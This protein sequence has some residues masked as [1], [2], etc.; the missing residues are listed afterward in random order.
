MVDTDKIFSHNDVIEMV[1][2]VLREF[3]VEWTDRIDN[4]LEE[5]TRQI[6][7]AKSHGVALSRA[8]QGL[9]ARQGYRHKPSA[10]EILIRHVTTRFVSAARKFGVLD[11]ARHL[12][13]ENFAKAITDPAAV[14]VATWAQELTIIGT[15]G[16]LL[17]VLSPQSAY[18][19]LSRR[20]LRVSVAANTVMR[21]P[22]RPNHQTPPPSPF[23]GQGQPVSIDAIMLSAAGALTDPPTPAGLLDGVAELTPSASTSPPVAAAQDIA[24]LV[25]AIIPAASDLVFIM[26]SGQALMARLLLPNFTA[27]IIE[28]DT[29][30]KG[31]VICLDASD[32]ASS[33]DDDAQITISDDA[34]VHTDDAAPLPI[35]T[36]SSGA[37]AVT[38]AP[39]MSVWQVD[40][41]AIRLSE[42]LDWKMRRPGR[43]SWIT[44][45]QW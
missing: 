43:V 16:G 3:H 45:T 28:S 26:N 32:F 18:A 25:A 33:A 21:L 37:G 24:A 17:P 15:Y 42:S 30:Q 19:Q 31:K 14:N 44:G 41:Q 22:Y 13:G 10:E 38:A 29:L 34:V 39:V 8:V 20:G 2:P 7:N 11:T 23:V 9:K 36:G 6:A 1:G 5:L 27:P 40:V 35:A 4:R 12:Y